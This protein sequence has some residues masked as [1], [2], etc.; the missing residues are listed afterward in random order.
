ME[1]VI[2][3]A[4][5]ATNRP[6]VS[7]FC[8][9][10][11]GDRYLRAAREE[12]VG[13][14]CITPIF[15]TTLTAALS[16]NTVAAAAAVATTVATTT[17]ATAT[18]AITA[19]ALTR[20]ESARQTRSQRH[21]FAYIHRPCPGCPA[22]SACSRYSTPVTS[23]AAPTPYV[24]E[25]P[26]SGIGFSFLAGF[27]THDPLKFTMTSNGGALLYFVDS[28]LIG[29]IE[30][31]HEARSTG[32]DRRCRPQHTQRSQHGHP[33]RLRHRRP[34]ISPRHVADG[35][36]C[37]GAWPS[38]IFGRDGGAQGDERGHRQRIVLGRWPVQD[39]STQKH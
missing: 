1:A 7:N 3:A 5:L 14:V 4:S 16:S 27:A 31:H 13:P 8:A 10:L 11:A 32:D 25:S 19:T 18:Y 39:Y 12:A 21:V 30:R 24:I 29:D 38:P 17:V 6:S 36:E 26:P 20:A 2:T 15:T 35:H 33:H 22:C 34:R 37:T 9:S 23:E 28:N